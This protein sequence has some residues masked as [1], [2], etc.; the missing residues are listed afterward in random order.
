MDNFFELSSTDQ[1]EILQSASA[2]LGRSGSVLEKDIWVC[3][4][5]S[6]L[7]SEELYGTHPMAFKGG[8]SLSKVYGVIKRFSEDIDVTLDYRQFGDDFDPFAEGVS[9]SAI[10]KF[11]ER[12]KQHV[13]QYA[14]GQ[15]V[16]AMEAAIKSLPM[17]DQMEINLD[18]N[19]E[20]IWIDYPSVVEGNDTY[21]KSQVLIELGGRNVIDPNE[22]KRISPDI[23]GLTNGVSFPV[24]DVVVLSPRRTFWEKAT[25]MHV[26]CMRGEWRD[27]SERLS[28]HWYD[29]A[30]LMRGGIGQEAIKDWS[31]AEDVVNHK[32]VFFNMG[33][34]NYD[35]FLDRNAKLVPDSEVVHRLRADYDKMT[36]AGMLYDEN[37]TFDSI[38]EEISELEEAINNR[39]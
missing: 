33:Y 38:M 20:K 18:E 2:N 26:E 35:A 23:V 29:S 31:L 14:H 30:M 37:P 16:P 4:A 8:T 12:L 19:G 21:L 27:H 7:F 17:G 3:W 11:S 6:I 5:L 10:R 1:K 15:I 24:A 32:K 39:V 13:E 9:K 36:K 25:L 28:R 22:K 34:A